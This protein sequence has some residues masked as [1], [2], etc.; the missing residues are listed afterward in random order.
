MA[1]FNYIAM[2]NKGTRKSG[3][4]DARSRDTAVSLLKEQGYYVLS[5]EEKKSTF[6]DSF[7]ELR[8][9]PFGDV[10]SF[11]RQFSTMIG[12]GLAISKAL[13]VLAA[14]TT[15]N[16]FR[17]ILNDV[18]RDVEGGASLAGALGRFP[19][20]FS[21]TYQSLVAAGEA[22][23]RL[24]EILKRLADTMEAERALRAKFKS[25]MIYPVIV[26]IAMGGVF[27][28]LM[29]S[30]VPKLAQL[31]ESMNIDLPLTTK[32]MI[33]VSEF[34]SNNL[35]LVILGIFGTILGIRYF[36]HTPGGELLKSRLS[37][38]MPVFGKI[39]KKKELTEFTRTLGLLVNSAVPIV[40]ALNIV[41]S[42]V[43]SEAYREGAKQA[44]VSIEKGGTLSNY[45]KQNENFP[46]IL[47]NM[48]ATGEETG[49]LDEILERLADFFDEETE[50]AV[51]SLS[52]ALEPVILILLG[53]M[54]G[55]LIISIITPIYKI[56]AS[57]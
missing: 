54:V 45:L 49:K 14:Q 6:M 19:D 31:Y 8:G 16:K 3:T 13:N 26:L 28:I 29:V 36:L 37:L 50:H 21:T 35:I 42:V 23:G 34:M 1:E 57:I 39:N 10:V 38:S 52:A 30:V 15:N 11:T 17:G 20:T 40:D 55:F 48:V 22:S 7:I 43:T 47:G 25:A 46:P 44:A 4:V 24:D 18:L 27:I 51:E 41:S 32:M 9:V 12:A 5:L 53:A 2:D 33:A 56:T